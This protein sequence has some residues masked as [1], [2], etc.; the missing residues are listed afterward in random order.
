MNPFPQALLTWFDKNGRKHLP[1]QQN[2]TPYRVWISEIMLQQTQVMTVIPYFERFMQRFADLSALATAAEDE[3]LHLWAGLGYYSRARHLHRAAKMVMAEFGGVFPDTLERLLTLPG[4][5]QS[6]AGA[7]LSIAYHKPTPILD[8]NV[9]RVLARYYGIR[10]PVNDKAVE[11]RMWELAAQNTP[12]QRVADY[13]QAIMDLG[14]TLCTRTKP[15]CA[16]CP[17]ESTCAAFA[18]AITHELPMKKAAKKIPVR[19]ATFLLAQHR[20]HVLLLRRP[21]S[22]I[23]G[24][25]WSLPEFSGEPD[26]KQLQQY[27]LREFG[28]TID[29]MK[30][31]VSFRHTFSHYH[32]DIHPVAIT[33]KRLPAK[34]M[35]AE[36]QIWYNPRNPSAIGLPKPVQQLLLSTLI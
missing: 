6:T 3:V 5:G 23:W 30:H 25:L 1:W 24:G 19:S 33:L 10:E 7:I 32:L 28:V 36:R 14:A 34:V 20:D 9:K 8:G 12:L 31:L 18:Q 21:T 27:C 13:T 35:E 2:K 26:K 16:D 17:F 4:I 29:E 11:N 15:N 22:G